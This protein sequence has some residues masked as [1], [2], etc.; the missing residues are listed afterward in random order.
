M[1]FHAFI[2]K[3]IISQICISIWRRRDTNTLRKFKSKNKIKSVLNIGKDL[4]E[5][6]DRRIL[7]ENT[8][9]DFIRQN[10][11]LLAHLENDTERVKKSQKRL[12]EVSMLLNKFSEQV[13]F[14]HQ[15]TEKSINFR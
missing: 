12:A 3:S 8:N 11:I 13:F 15:T 5:L 9:T 14:Q 2:A 7:K 1:Q 4:T 6:E 10:E